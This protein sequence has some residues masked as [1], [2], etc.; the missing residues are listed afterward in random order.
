[1]S[2]NS[3]LFSARKST[4]ELVKNPLL[5]LSQA[6]V[7]QSLLYAVVLAIN[8]F[9]VPIDPEAKDQTKNDEITA[10]ESD[11]T[12]IVFIESAHPFTDTTNDIQEVIV[13]GIFRLQVISCI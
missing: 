2:L 13:P 3:P 11:E 10:N 12:A 9:D 8:Y 6:E 4:I 5:S 7:Y 1:M